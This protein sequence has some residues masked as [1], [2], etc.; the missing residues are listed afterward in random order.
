ME[1]L[2]QAVMYFDNILIVNIGSFIHDDNKTW[3]SLIRN[4]FAKFDPKSS[5]FTIT[6]IFIV[7]DGKLSS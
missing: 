5:K 4:Y 1:L 3:W 7:T 6:Y 2:L